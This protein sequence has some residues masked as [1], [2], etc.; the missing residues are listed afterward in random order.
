M[1]AKFVNENVFKSK[2]LSPDEQ[3]LWDMVKKYD[4][5][6]L[7]TVVSRAQQSSG[8]EFEFEDL[9]PE[10]RSMVLDRLG[11]LVAEKV[12]WDS[13]RDLFMPGVEYAIKNG[14]NV[15]GLPLRV[16]IHYVNPERNNEEKIKF[17]KEMTKKLLD[18][19]STLKAKNYEG[20]KDAI[21]IG[22]KDLLNI[23]IK[24]DKTFDNPKAQ[25]STATK[26]LS[27]IKEKI[28]Q[29]KNWSNEYMEEDDKNWLRYYD[30][31]IKLEELGEWL[32]AKHLK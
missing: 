6:I 23:I 1:K 7:K 32:E 25:W 8:T 28:K 18:A 22:D 3:K 24:Y 20:L 21:D 2:E 29:Y 11:P 16:A 30:K 19:G 15:N 17:G 13:E 14:L 5:N 4:S 27:L 10:H 26:T 31:A 9:E 12:F